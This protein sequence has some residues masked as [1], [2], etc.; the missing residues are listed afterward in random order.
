[1]IPPTGNLSEFI[2]TFSILVLRQGLRYR[3]LCPREIKI[4]DLVEAIVA[5][6][7]IPLD[8]TGRKVKMAVT[9]KAVTLVDLSMRNVRI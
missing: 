6:V 8:S 2:H 4:G 5:P 7:C 3:P 1:L 9:L